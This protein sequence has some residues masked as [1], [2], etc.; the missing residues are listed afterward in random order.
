MSQ[1]DILKKIIH[2]KW[3]EITERQNDAPQTDLVERCKNLPST[4]GFVR[5]LQQ[6]IQAGLPAV[7]AEIKRASPSKGLIRDPFI[8]AEIA[9]S[10]ETYGAACLS[11]LTDHDF[12]QGHE[13]YLIAAHHACALPILRKDFTVDAY[14]VYEARALGADCILLIVAAL[15]DE[16][17]LELYQLAQ[18]L[19]MDVLVEVHDQVELQRALMLDPL[20]DTG[21]PMI[22]INNR[23]LRS[24]ET[25]LNTTLSLLAEIPKHM[26]VVTE[27]AIHTRNDV[28]L[29]R[30]HHVH[31][32]LVG[33][34]FM[35]EPVP[36]VKLA[37]LFYGQ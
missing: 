4:R 21:L 3:E 36:G 18:A 9:H 7:I 34:A 26:L 37:E 12:F 5:A 16:K 20:S 1:T 2:R 27:S 10:Y 35:R 23:N 22:G 17:L 30:Q 6:K 28:E 33:E 11:V 13:D 14:Q 31:G 8:P 25:T 15:T 19:G 29:M 24:F 32:F